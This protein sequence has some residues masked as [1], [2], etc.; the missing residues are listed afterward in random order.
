MAVHGEEE[1]RAKGSFEL[2][3]TV[4]ES[5]QEKRRVGG[6]AEVTCQRQ[7]YSII[8][9][10][11]ILI[12]RTNLL[13]NVLNNFYVMITFIQSFVLDLVTCVSREVGHVLQNAFLHDTQGSYLCANS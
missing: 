3:Q 4:E 2:V 8:H 11:Q 6:G 10:F 9:T 13:K 7:M 12:H 1:G 5:R